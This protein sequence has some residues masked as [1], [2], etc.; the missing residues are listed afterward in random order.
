M[1]EENKMEFH[2]DEA[3][4]SNH[5]K[6]EEEEI[7]EEIEE[8]VTDLEQEQGFQVEQVSVESNH[9]KI[10][11]KNKEIPHDNPGIEKQVIMPKDKG[12]EINVEIQ[13][14]NVV[15]NKMEFPQDEAEKEQKRIS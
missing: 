12:E 9:P 8:T 13:P 2:Q 5:P 10:D 1:G 11:V 4:K 15:E 14:P 7:E 3:K 6:R